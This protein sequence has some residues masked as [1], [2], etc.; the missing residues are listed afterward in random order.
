[1]PVA[2]GWARMPAKMSRLKREARIGRV[3]LAR[4]RAVIATASDRGI[5]CGLVAM[6]VSGR[7]W[8]ALVASPGVRLS[9][10]LGHFPKGQTRVFPSLRI[11]G[12]HQ[13]PI[14]LT[15]E[16]DELHGDPGRSLVLDDQLHI[17]QNERGT[18]ATVLVHFKL[19]PDRLAAERGQVECM[20]RETG[21]RVL[22]G[23][24]LQR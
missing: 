11:L 1:M 13:S 3:P 17:I 18:Q 24:G 12:V 8:K 4:A 16:G 15:P 10:K 2:P 14:P 9:F 23:E 20:C 7:L 22:V 19:D 6:V 21:G 5:L